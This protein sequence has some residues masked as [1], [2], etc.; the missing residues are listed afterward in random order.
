[1]KIVKDHIL[2]ARHM[3]ESSTCAYVE[4]LSNEPN[5]TVKIL[6]KRMHY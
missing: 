1:M 4:W 3:H 6:N 5:M 2:I